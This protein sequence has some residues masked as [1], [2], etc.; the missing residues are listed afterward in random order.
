LL[1]LLILLTLLTL[2]SHSAAPAC[3]GEQRIDTFDD[4]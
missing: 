2:L 3:L 1:T 4:S